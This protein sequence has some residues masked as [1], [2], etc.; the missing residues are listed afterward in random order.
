MSN[1]ITP[2]E[3]LSGISS[4]K[5][6]PKFN[7]KKFIEAFKFMCAMSETEDPYVKPA[8]KRYAKCQ[9][10]LMNQSKSNNI[11]FIMTC[12]I[13]T[14]YEHHWQKTEYLYKN[15]EEDGKLYDALPRKTIDTITA[16]CPVELMDSCRIEMY[17]R[18][19]LVYGPE[20]KRVPYEDYPD[21]HLIIAMLAVTNH[22]LQL[23]C[24]PDLINETEL[25]YISSV[26]NP[27][28]I[29]FTDG[30]SKKI[31][32][33]RITG[34]KYDIKACRASSKEYPYTKQGVVQ[35]ILEILGQHSVPD[36]DRYAECL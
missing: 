3:F 8:L 33:K 5:E 25:C 36:I 16:N 2:N 22:I 28:T 27:C 9:K 13:L 19:L 18:M 20:N 31:T 15:V 29:I 32:V 34:R 6:K 21:N 26:V 7:L 14:N 12:L 11:S 23:D 1:H 4:R 30:K 17:N 10:Y 35:S 24:S